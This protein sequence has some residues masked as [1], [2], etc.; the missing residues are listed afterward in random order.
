[1]LISCAVKNPDPKNEDPM[2][3]KTLET[4]FEKYKNDSPNQ[5][6]DYLFETNRD[7]ASGQMKDL[8]DKL[9]SVSLLAGAYH[10]YEPITVQKK[11]SS[12]IYYSFL[13]RHE[14]LPFR[15]IF[16]FYKPNEKWKILK[17]KFDDQLDTEL[18]QAG[19]IYYL[20]QN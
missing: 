11:S 2:L 16:I 7:V 14:R 9:S 1:M 3:K 17:F 18:E 5:A 12:L 4:F 20:Q 10:G 6:V 19:K 13:V 15:F 8:K